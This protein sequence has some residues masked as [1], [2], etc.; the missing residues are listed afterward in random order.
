[1]NRLVRSVSLV[2]VVTLLFTILLAAG[3]GS[4]EKA[5]SEQ[6]KI[7]KVG[8]VF[9]ITGPNAWVGEETTNAWKMILDKAN[10]GE[11]G[12]PKDM[13]IQYFIEDDR[14]NATESVA[15]ATKL[16]TREKVSVILGPFNSSVAGP[17]TDYTEKM[18]VPTMLGGA[19][20][21]F[22]CQRG[23]Q[24]TFR[25]NGNNTMQARALPTWL[26]QKRN[27][28]DIVIIHQQTDWGN[29][30]QEAT[31]KTVEKLGGNIVGSFS[32]EPN[33]T[34]FYSLLTKIKTLQYDGIILAALNDELAPLVRQ[35][36]ELGIPANKMLG[37]GVDS[38]K[39]IEMA[40][41]A[42][43]GFL[44][45]GNFDNLKPNNPEAKAFADE[46]Q[47]KFN[48]LPSLY[49]AQGWVTGTMLIEALKIAKSTDPEGIREALK[50]LKQVPTVFGKIQY[51][52]QNEAY[53]IYVILE[54]KDK[55]LNSI[56]MI[57]EY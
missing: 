40:G 7:V 23:Y 50:S 10:N 15:A 52:D 35:A 32:Y 57:T 42:A 6:E 39:L 33:N 37:Y 22:L 12:L 5:G 34:D 46:Y 24:Y 54:V 9:P 17:V 41:N 30:L 44:T 38:A 36:N 20:A 2:L 31:E 45:S 29:G 55:Q 11:M 3:C 8:I 48:R 56:D 51:D 53:P 25:S 21:D 28:K 13:K 14:S 47:A 18:K 26:M 43:E 49:A 19:A 27:W 4:Q 1:M 16:I